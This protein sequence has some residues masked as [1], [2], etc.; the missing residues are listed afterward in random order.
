MWYDDASDSFLRPWPPEIVEAHL[1]RAKEEERAGGRRRGC[2]S[3]ATSYF[4]RSWRVVFG[5]GARS[6][7]TGGE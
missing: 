5:A 1:P 6:G 7:R 3:R 4:M 2:A